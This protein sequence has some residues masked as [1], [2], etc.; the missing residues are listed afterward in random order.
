MPDD[1]TLREALVDQLAYLIDEIEMLRGRIDR[2]PASI[3]EAR[4][5][6]GDLSVKELFGLIATRDADVRLPL[7]RR[8]M[9]EAEPVFSPADDRA[10]VQGGGW[11][12]RSIE[13][14]LTELQ[15]ARRA[16]VEAVQALPAAA[17]TRTARFGEASRSVYELLHAA[18][19]QD[20]DDLRTLG[21]RLYESNLSGRPQ[22][23]PK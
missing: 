2:V 3:L 10:L 5:L 8:M 17:W 22:G 12:D 14:I 13:A 16:L 23:L 6:P 21:Y 20:A 4:P 19:Q 7:L 11:N 18:I 1:A 15:A 9:A